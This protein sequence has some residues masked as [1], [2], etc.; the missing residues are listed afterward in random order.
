MQLK[1]LV[2]TLDQMT[3]DEL[4]ERLREVRHRR[5]VER[6][7]HRAHVERAERKESTKRMSA[8]DKL[9]SSLSEAERDAL[10]AQ[11]GGTS[12]GDKEEEI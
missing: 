2:K 5:S 6:P 8:L 1:D 10:M 11:L 12:G 7:A 4:L 3:D 9:L